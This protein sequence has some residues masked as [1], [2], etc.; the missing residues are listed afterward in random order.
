MIC[1]FNATERKEIRECRMSLTRIKTEAT[2]KGLLI[3]SRAI[4]IL[5][6]RTLFDMYLKRCPVGKYP[7]A[8]LD[9]LLGII[10]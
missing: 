5:A 1:L 2:T 7:Q 4:S 6:S 8:R 10:S 9:R 3:I